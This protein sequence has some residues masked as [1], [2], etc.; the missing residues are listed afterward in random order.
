[1]Q[2]RPCI[3]QHIDHS[4]DTS[5]EGTPVIFHGRASAPNPDHYRA[6]PIFVPA[7]SP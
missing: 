4:R 2:R 5:R 3:P 1:M 6:Y 7:D